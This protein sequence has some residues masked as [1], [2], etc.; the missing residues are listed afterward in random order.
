MSARVLSQ[1]V[2]IGFVLLGLLTAGLRYQTRQES[3]IALED[4]L[5][6]L[7]YEL[8]FTAKEPLAGEPDATLRI[9]LPTNRPHLEVVNPEYIHNGLDSKF[10]E[11]RKTGN[12]ELILTTKHGGEYGVTAEFE[13]RL[14]PDSSWDLRQSM[15][16]LTDVSR[17]RFIRFEDEFPVQSAGVQSVVRQTPKGEGNIGEILQS[18]FEHCTNLESPGKDEDGADNVEWALANRT[19]S[20]LGK[21]R[22]MVTLCRAARIP[23]RLVA[24]FELRQIDDPQPHVW[25]EVFYGHH[26]VPFDPALGYARH[27]PINFIPIRRGGEKVVRAKGANEVQAKY[28]IRRLPPAQA[29]LETELRRPSQIF[30]LTRLPVEMHE[31]MSLMLLLPLGALIT[32]FFRNVIGIRTFGTFAPALLAIS[33]IYAAWGTGIVILIVVIVTGLVGRSLLERLHLLMVPRLSI[34]LTLIILC[35]AFSVSLLDYLEWTHSAQAVL[36]PLV[37]LTI[38]IE[39]FHVTAEEDGIAFALQL[40]VGTT[41]VSAFCY[42]LLKWDDIGQLLLIYPE[43]HFFTIAVFIL[44]GRYSGYRLVELWRFR[45]LVK[46]NKP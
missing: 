5:W 24:G 20:S 13:I 3:Q 14:S 2:V 30:D 32:A 34:V 22:S 42:L 16:S 39:R 15:E 43:A 46:S 6:R 12:H 40:V 31:V 7:T 10:I 41:I 4:S 28:S 37:I 9:G 23:A 17:A 11:W 35:V 25:L 26:W 45:D 19:A 1:L 44:I 36:L 8:K 29:V 18:L 38:L 27:M 33:F 21:A